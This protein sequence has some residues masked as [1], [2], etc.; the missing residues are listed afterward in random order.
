MAQMATVDSQDI[1]EALAIVESSDNPDAPLGDGG[2]AAGRWQ[3]HPIFLAEMMKTEDADQPLWELFYGTWDEVFHRFL[4]GWVV[5][6]LRRG[7]E[8]VRIALYFHL[9]HQGEIDL[10]YARKFTMALD[11]VTA[12]RTN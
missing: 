10:D 4:T 9:G 5:R 6:Q 1:L 7:L 2:R 12:R 8:P 3:I 11:K